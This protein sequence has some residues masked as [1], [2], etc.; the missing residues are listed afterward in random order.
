MRESDRECESAREWS[1]RVCV[2]HGNILSHVVLVFSFPI[3]AFR[4][5]AL[6]M[7]V[8]MIPVVVYVNICM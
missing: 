1:V 5:R 8:C 7:G 4:V 2:S 3:F 6:S